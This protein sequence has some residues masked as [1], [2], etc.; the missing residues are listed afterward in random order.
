MTALYILEDL[1]VG[2]SGCVLS[3]PV[4]TGCL[5]ATAAASSTPPPPTPAHT[6]S[7]GSG[8]K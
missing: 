6:C 8:V 2:C 7:A 1:V 3:V 5:P 4:S